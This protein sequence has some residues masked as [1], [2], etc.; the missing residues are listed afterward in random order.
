MV[1]LSGRQS[2]LKPFVSSSER[3]SRTVVCR[4]T[5][6]RKCGEVLATVPTCDACGEIVRAN[7]MMM[8]VGPY[9]GEKKSLCFHADCFQLWN[10][11]RQ[12]RQS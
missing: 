11:A 10:A 8:E 3:S 12:T 1:F 6:P 2:K 9:T 7:Q 4:T 5:A